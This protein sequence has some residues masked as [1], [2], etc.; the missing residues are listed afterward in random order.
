MWYLN[1]S[2]WTHEIQFQSV[3]CMHYTDN[4]LIYKLFTLFQRALVLLITIFHLLNSHMC[5]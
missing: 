2:E 1:S 4:D 5:I 3:A